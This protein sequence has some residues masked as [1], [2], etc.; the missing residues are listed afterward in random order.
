MLRVVVASAILAGC[1]LHTDGPP[2]LVGR[3]PTRGDLDACADDPETPRGKFRHTTNRTL[4]RIG[5]PRH[6]GYDLIAVESDEK[7]TLGGKLAYT[8]ADKDLG[9]EDVIVYG[10]VRGAWRRLGQATTD[11]HG[12]FELVLTGDWR[13]PVGTREL[14]AAVPG[15]G[16]SVRFVAHV[17][18]PGDAVIVTDLDGTVTESENAVVRNVMFGDDI[19]HRTAA[20]QVF[21]ASRRAIVYVSSRSERFTDATRRWLAAHGFPAGPIRL[22]QS[23]VTRPGAKTVALKTEILRSL[24]VPIHAALG[25]RRSD[26]LAYRAAG[27]PGDRI[28]VKLPEFERELRD[29]LDAKQCVG[30][31]RYEE[32]ATRLR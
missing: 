28:F 12:K 18:K 31:L 22:G 10:C 19:G 15:D 29:I 23:L 4:A 5:R 9:H 16:S 2:E 20:P 17:A 24:G 30:F 3:R 7:Q 32:V 6:R 21:A 27:V 25:N 26:V 13:L 11:E 1:A 8:R 14:F